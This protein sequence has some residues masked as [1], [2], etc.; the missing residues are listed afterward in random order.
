[1]LEAIP[2]R[3]RSGFPS[4]IAEK[5]TV[6]ATPRF[7]EKG[8][9]PH[10]SGLLALFWVAM[11]VTSPSQA[12][13]VKTA[14]LRIDRVVGPPISR[15]DAPP[16]DLGF[17]GAM[18]GNEDNRT[19]GA[20]TGMDYTVTTQAVAPE[21]AGAALDGLKAEGIGL[22]AVIAEGD[23]LKELSE[24]AGPG[25]LLFNAGAR[26][27]GLRDADCLANVLHVS[28]SRSMLSDS[29]V[30]FLMWK[31]W[32][33]I[34]LIHG[35]HPEDRLLA[36]SYRKSAAKFGAKIVEEREFVDTGGSRR[37]DTGHVMVQKQIPVFTQEAEPYDVIVAADEAGVFAPYLPYHS[38]DPRPIAG[39]AGLRPVSWHPAHEAW[40]ATQFQRRFEKLTGRYMREEDYQA[41]L[42][43]RVIGEAV[44][45]SG[46]ADPATVRAYALSK[47]F[48]LAAFKG[49][50]LTFRTWNGQ[51]RQPV[52]LTEGRVTV[53]VSP[54][55]GYLHQHS[56][57]D[58]LGIDA[59][60]TAC[61]AFGG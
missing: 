35:S 26:D 7:R 18:L 59:P 37:T 4:G 16:A 22:I 20:F 53:S 1:M 29:I 56:P 6:R 21:E 40:G 45:R 17:A 30:Q 43:M 54:Q 28:P 25:V 10:L 48:E 9:C 57:L 14:V 8:K 23:I 11:L 15:L 19:T 46:K 44:T 34:L 12:A 61:Q 27:D 60:E 49:Q 13:E 31:K 50:K 39:S 33:R 5:R 32:P 2:G 42:A 52:L 51:L 47:D 41:W 36:E 55:D 3:V 38:W 58:T 24:K